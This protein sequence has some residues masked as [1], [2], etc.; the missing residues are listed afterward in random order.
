MVIL[1]IFE[2]IGLTIWAFI[3]AVF[4][5]FP[6]FNQIS[7]LKDQM[8]AYIFGVPV[9]VISLIGAIPLILKIIKGIF[10]NV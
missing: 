10:S 1:E 9:I 2:V 6:I 5:L 8:I 4:S 7:D 3:K